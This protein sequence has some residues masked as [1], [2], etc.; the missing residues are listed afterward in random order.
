MSDNSCLGLNNQP[1]PPYKALSL[2]IESDGTPRGTL[3]V[4]EAGR[5]L[6]GVTAVYFALNVKD[7]VASAVIHVNRLPVSI[8]HPNVDQVVDE[9]EVKALPE[10]PWSFP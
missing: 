7:Q 3:V 1:I 4:D 8:V 10:S 2:R 6:N 5:I 9:V